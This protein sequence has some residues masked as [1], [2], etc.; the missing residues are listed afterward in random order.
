VLI[1]DP[2]KKDPDGDAALAFSSQMLRPVAFPLIRLNPA[3]DSASQLRVQAIPGMSKL[4]GFKEDTTLAA[5]LPWFPSMQDRMGVANQKQDADGIVRKYPIRWSE[6]GYELP[7]LVGRV[8]ELSDERVH[9]EQ[10]TI[11]LNWRNKRGRYE[12]ISFS[13]LFLNQ[14]SEKQVQALK[15]AHVILGV[16]APGLGQVKPTSVAAVEDDAE[17]LAT[18]L[19]DALHDTHLRTMPAALVLVLNIIAIWVLV[20]ISMRP[21]QNQTINRLFILIQSAF[22]GVTLF[23]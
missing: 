13:D 6:N 23:D 14:L 15:G 9:S 10:S 1:S 22:G 4:N 18:A 2:D 8:I 21:I 11:S 20:A 3:N 16:S 12:R 19:D 5:V 17:I 7:S